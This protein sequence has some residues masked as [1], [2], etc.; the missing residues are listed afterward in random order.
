MIRE[1]F[2]KGNIYLLLTIYFLLG[3][4]LF[5]SYQYFV[6]VDGICYISIA[7][8]YAVGDYQNA[9]NGFWSPLLSWVLA[10][11]AK[12]GFNPLNSL[13][14][15]NLFVGAFVLIVINRILL[16]QK[17][18]RHFRLIGL[19]VIAVEILFFSLTGSFPDLFL[20]LFVFLLYKQVVINEEKTMTQ[21]LLLGVIGA[22]GYFTKAYFFWF[23]LAIG[24]ILFIWDL[25][26]YPARRKGTLKK[27]AITLSVFFVFSSIWIVPVSLKYNQFKISSAGGFNHAILKYDK[28]PLYFSGITVPTTETDI[29]IAEEKTKLYLKMKTWSPFSSLDNSI[30]Q[31]KIIV[32]NIIKSL[33]MLSLRNPLTIIIIFISGYFIFNKRKDTSL[34]D[35]PLFQMF[36][37]SSVFISGYLLLIGLTP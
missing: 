17:I 34:R 28:N 3:V 8:K 7:H 19:G 18:S 5:Q 4:F 14:G 30:L 13:K 25:K 6:S 2:Y 37:F 31:L 22:L 12:F 26:S 16:Q 1:L 20:L 27:F 33:W 10:P 23:F 32:K 24:I 9:I 35:Y 11:F 21:A 36:L 15:I 29:S